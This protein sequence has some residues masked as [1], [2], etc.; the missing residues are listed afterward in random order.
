MQ[1]MAIEAIER[2]NFTLAPAE[3]AHQI[4]E[5]GIERCI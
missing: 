3:T 4:P 2:K 1:G 5:R